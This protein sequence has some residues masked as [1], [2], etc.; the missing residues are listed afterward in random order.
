[1][2][3]ESKHKTEREREKDG[4]GEKGRGANGKKKEKKKTLQI[5]GDALTECDCL[6][7]EAQA[8]VATVM[9]G[10]GLPKA[11]QSEE[12]GGKRGRD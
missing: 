1:M 12:G 4:G 2:V 9:T 3:Y 6:A 5:H 8:D 7:P 11:L 10:D